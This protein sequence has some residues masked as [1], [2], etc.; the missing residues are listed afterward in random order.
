MV[1]VKSKTKKELLLL[2]YMVSEIY[3]AKG[4]AVFKSV[5]D[6]YTDIETLTKQIENIYFETYLKPQHNEGGDYE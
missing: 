1:E 5:L 4:D 3:A 2:A 6:N